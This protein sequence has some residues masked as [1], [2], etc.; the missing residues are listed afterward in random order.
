MLEAIRNFSLTRKEKEKTFYK[1]N[2]FEISQNKN[3]DVTIVFLFDG[4][5]VHE[6][7]CQ[8]IFF[9]QGDKIKMW[10]DGEIEITNFQ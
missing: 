3:N 6:Q 1:Y 8:Q 5:V 2:S 4:T 10:A 7:T 9:K